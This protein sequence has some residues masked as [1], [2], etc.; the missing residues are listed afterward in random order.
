MSVQNSHQIHQA[1]LHFPGGGPASHL[2]TPEVSRS[3]SVIRDSRRPTA[4]MVT[5]RGSTCRSL[6][7]TP[8]V[9]GAKKEN[10]GVVS[11]FPKKTSYPGMGVNFGSLV[12]LFDTSISKLGVE[13]I[14]FSILLLPDPIQPWEIPPRRC[15]PYPP[16]LT[17][18][19]PRSSCRSLG[20]G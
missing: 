16:L 2:R 3:V 9:M 10:H 7:V 11:T 13:L 1:D 5:D 6:A 12:D 8:F 14:F 18:Y 15:D 17:S 19:K 4:A 20:Y